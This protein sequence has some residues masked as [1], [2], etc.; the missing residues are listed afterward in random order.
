MVMNGRKRPPREIKEP[1]MSIT[2]KFA[3]VAIAAVTLGAAMSATTGTAEAKKWHGHGGWGW[4]GA[5]VAAGLIGA[6]IASHAYASDYYYVGGPRCRWVRQFNSWGHY[7]GKA[8]VCNY[9]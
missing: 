9:Y 3:A 2:T 6:G 4:G 1:P 5:A 7:V 8:K